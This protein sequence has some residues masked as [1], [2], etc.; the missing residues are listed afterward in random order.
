MT[1]ESLSSII[2][3]YSLSLYIPSVRY[4]QV[5]DFIDLYIIHAICSHGAHTIENIMHA[6]TDHNNPDVMIYNEHRR[7]D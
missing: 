4:I 7:E 5:L 6:L 3:L 2:S 1:G